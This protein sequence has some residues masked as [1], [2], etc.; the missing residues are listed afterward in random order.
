MTRADNRKK[1]VWKPLGLEVLG[2]ENGIP[3]TTCYSLTLPAIVIFPDLEVF[4]QALAYIKLA[5]E[6]Y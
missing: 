5:L 1:L 2:S 3:H 4:S 6:G